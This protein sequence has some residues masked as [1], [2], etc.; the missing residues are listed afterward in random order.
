MENDAYLPTVNV[1]ARFLTHLKGI[2]RVYRKTSAPKETSLAS[3][4]RNH[5]FFLHR[6]AC[7]FA[8]TDAGG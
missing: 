2:P 3:P 4:P 1:S 5:F 6:R 8:N 7:T